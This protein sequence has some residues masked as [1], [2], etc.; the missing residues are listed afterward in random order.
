MKI[1]SW[2]CQNGIIHKMDE[3]KQI[4]EKFN[5][6]IFYVSE[7]EL[8]NDMTNFVSLKNYNID[9]AG[10]I[11][12]GKA[13]LIAYSKPSTSV[14][15]RDLEGAD[16]NIIVHETCTE[17][18]VGVY[19]GFKNYRSAGFD[20]VGY[21]FS[22]LDECCKTEKKVIIIGDFN[23]DP[24]R[25]LNTPQGRAL[26]L[27]LI[28]NGLSQKVDFITR[29][30][31]VNRNDILTLEESTI[32]L[33]LLSDQCDGEIISDH[34]T[35]D[36]KLLGV[37]TKENITKAVTKKLTIRDWSTLTPRGVAKAISSRPD[38]TT[39]EEHTTLLKWVLD[40]LAPFRVIRTRMPENMVNPKIE[41]IRKRR[42]R[43]YRKYKITQDIHDLK[44]VKVENAKLKRTIASETK[45]IFQK[46]AE[47]A[48]TKC[49][50]QMINQMQGKVKEK[51]I[52]ILKDGVH[53]QDNKQLADEFAQ[54]FE[55]K[56]LKLT[57]GS[58]S[59]SEVSFE[60]QRM[61]NFTMTELEESL[62]FFKTKMSSGPD[63]IPMRLV[64]FYTLKRP[65]TIL[66][67]FNN[68]LQNGF[69]DSWRIARVTPVPKKGVR[70]DINNYRPVS[71]LPSLSK[72]FERCILHRLMA[73]PNYQDLVGEHQHGFRPHHSTT[74]CLLQLKDT[75][76]DRL[77]RKKK[78]LAYS[79]DLSAAFDMLR[80]DTFNT[81][82]Q[83][84]LPND[85]LG[86]IN[87]F[88]C[89]RKFYV[90]CNGERSRMSQ[91]DRGCPQGSVLGPVLFNLYTSS[92]CTKL[93]S[94]V[95]LTAYADNSYVIVEDDELENL[96]SK[97]ELCLTTHIACL[98]DIGMKVNDSKTEIIYFGKDQANI[99]L[100][101]RG[102]PV[103]SKKPH[104]GTRYLPRQKSKLGCSYHIPKE[105]SHVSHRWCKDDQK[106]TEP[107]SSD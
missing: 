64:K 99:T 51:D 41:K 78:V 106:Q 60:N 48:N 22:L 12:L 74:T 69:P 36:H 9:L 14:R 4:I 77:D 26:D 39:L 89:K 28:N 80:P 37:I 49:F 6:D 8:V 54:F 81:T 30:R 79:L 63:E 67:I 100:N 59:V 23:I 5:P 62:K 3:V 96:I 2:N 21:L 43:I 61:S 7:S 1:L 40:I 46:K 102:A 88:L 42:D 104:Q 95:S 25:D 31:V 75:I 72:L 87:E 82:M 13:R 91:I 52:K 16:E 105:K 92:I 66:A 70:T 53:I 56:I 76:C 34:T 18:I 11:N 86:I 15:R 45:R 10:S 101:I 24:E 20:S 32:D 50:W 73:L 71:N 38:P 90:E 57:S 84:K 107:K 58:T 94:S 29:S 55:N 47:T 33:V 83:G 65:D 98:E 93:P 97:T 85:I 68:I 27:L 44:K 103:E 35:S 17:R 19:R